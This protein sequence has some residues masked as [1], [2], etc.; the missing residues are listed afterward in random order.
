MHDL[1]KGQI[2]QIKGPLSLL[3]K[4]LLGRLFILCVCLFVK[5]FLCEAKF[6]VSPNKTFARLIKV[7]HSF[8]TYS[9][10][11]RYSVTNL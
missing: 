7:I 8:V 6:Y 5:V 3:L 11:H 4:L 1:S 2:P 9:V 10:S